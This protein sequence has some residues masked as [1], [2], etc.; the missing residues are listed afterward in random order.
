MKIELSEMELITFRQDF[1]AFKNKLQSIDE[2]TGE[3]F[4]DLGDLMTCI[5]EL[6][7]KLDKVMS[8]LEPMTSVLLRVERLIQRIEITDEDEAN[9]SIS[10]QPP[11][12]NSDVPEYSNTGIKHNTDI[13]ELEPPDIFGPCDKCHQSMCQ[14]I[15]GGGQPV[16]ESCLEDPCICMAQYENRSD[17]SL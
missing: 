10:T 6:C 1:V 14:C 7:E 3:G 17:T 9:T 8:K 16:C 5:T 4:S 13:R 11:P 12:L 2:S 15:Q